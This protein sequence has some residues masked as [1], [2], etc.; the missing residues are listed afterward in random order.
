MSN[1]VHTQTAVA[2]DA[3]HWDVGGHRI[4]ESTD[5]G[6][7]LHHR[8]GLRF[9][10]DSAG[11]PIATVTRHLDWTGEG[12]ETTGGAATF[13]FLGA[14]SEDMAA[15]LSLQ[16][17][18]TRAV[19]AGGYR[20][21]D[22]R[23]RP[24]PVRDA[25]L[26]AELD[27]A[28]ATLP[29]PPG[30]TTL[31]VGLTAAG[32][33]AWAAA[34]TGRRPVAGTIRL[35]CSY[36]RLMP[37]ATAVVRLHGRKVYNGLSAS[38]DRAAD[39]ELSGT[40]AE[41]RAAWA[42]LV[43]GG[44][45]EVTFSGAPAG[46]LVAV[47]DGLVDQIRENLFDLMFAVRPGA[48]TG[49]P[50]HVLRW[51]RA[52][53]VPDLPLTVTV[54]GLTWLTTTLEASVAELLARLDSG[55]VHDV[56]SAVSVPVTVDVAPCDLVASVV[57]SLDFGDLRPPEVHT[58]DK[59]GG[60]RRVT[61]T[62][63]HPGQFSVGYRAQLVFSPPRLPVVPVRGSTSPGD[64]HVLLRPERWL[65]RQEFLLVVSEDGRAGTWQ[66]SDTM[67]V[68]TRCGGAVRS[69]A[70]TPG[71]PVTIT[72]AVVDDRP[73]QCALTVAGSVGGVLVQ[74]TRECRVDGGT[75]LIL[76]ENGALRI[77]TADD[78][79][80]GPR[81]EP[82]V[83]REIPP[84]AEAGRGI[85]VTSPVALVPQP[86]TVSGWAAAIAMVAGARERKPITAA[87][88]AG[89]AGMDLDTPYEWPRIR[90]AAGAWRL[91]EELVAGLSP[92]DW[93]A[94]LLD[95]GP[96]WVVRP[97]SPHRGVVVSG[98]TGDGTPEGTSVRVNDP[99]P[100]ATGAVAHVTFIRFD[101]EFGAGART[102]LVH[103]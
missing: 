2:A 25:V 69:A 47:R 77:I 64:P 5:P 74:G 46:E 59:A 72:H 84:D 100:P 101:R 95:W 67:T 1:P 30:G 76:V 10:A 83:R 92:R 75:V 14:D 45:V 43:R 18:W 17:T 35:S 96:I 78:P 51:K 93:A 55:V 27:A 103:G 61:V 58:F 8:T 39:G 11:R 16:D 29:G 34:V 94:L 99:W 9:A 24:L 36:P 42:G 38:L 31:Q 12:Y 6:V 20:G 44:A 3:A 19:R 53:D 15:V 90:E 98:I 50:V 33:D 54:G 7:L 102:A 28:D 23:Y 81:G 56:R 22:P 49:P 63:E 48:T 60:T 57:V 41:I 68:S 71:L 4:W 80:D 86:T 26:S 65:A 37:P 82:V 73:A 88:V 89:D 62:T 13:E 97:D 32:A 52:A 21:P 87:Q 40:A 91:A 70:V 79:F 66:E 85:A